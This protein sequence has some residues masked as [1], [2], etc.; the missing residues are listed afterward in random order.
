MRGRLPAPVRMLESPPHEDQARL[1]ELIQ[2]AVKAPAEDVPLLRWRVR[3]TL[4]RRDERRR[5]MLRGLMVGAVMFVAGGVVGAVMGPILIPKRKP[6]AAAPTSVR[7]SP[8]V[9]H[10]RWPRA[11]GVPVPAP[12]AETAEELQPLPDPAVAEDL[13]GREAASAEKAPAV[14]TTVG[15]TPGPTLAMDAESVVPRVPAARHAPAAQV[16][17]SPPSAAKLG[18]A[19]SSALGPGSTRPTP[20][21]L[22]APLSAVASVRTERGGPT[23][24]ELMVPAHPSTARQLVPGEQPVAPAEFFLPPPPPSLPIL[25]SPA[26]PPSPVA[27]PGAA[28]EAPAAR[29]ASE[30][31]MLTRALH[32]LRSLRDAHAALALLDEYTARFP[33]GAL[34]PEAARLRTEALLFLDRRQAALDELERNGSNA[35][36]TSDEQRLL[37]GELRAAVGRWQGAMEDFDAVVRARAA[38]PLAGDKRSIDH[39]ERALWGRASA[40]SHLGNQAGARSDLLEYQRRFPRGRHAAEVTRLLGGLHQR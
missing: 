24:G 11:P 2:S 31:I 5:L 32:S 6:E 15:P 30:P 23:L 21:A 9:A 17:V 25:P 40:R 10:K 38:E 29:Q 1:A 8:G 26:R 36:A 39:L 14:P 4:R 20:T 22:R 28:P 3:S 13:A 34:A 37:R 33:S 7:T 18:N 16:G 12:I 35:V 27:L 19:R